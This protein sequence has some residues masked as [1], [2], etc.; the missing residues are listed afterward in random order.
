MHYIR[1]LV[2]L[3]AIGAPCAAQAQ[4]WDAMPDRYRQD[5][6]GARP[7]PGYDPLGIPLLGMTLHSD[8]AVATSYDSNIFGRSRDVVADG[9]I[10]IRPAMKM[11]GD[12][13]RYALTL[14]AQG[15]FTRFFDLHDQDSD[16]YQLGADGRVNL[17]SDLSLG[18]GADFGRQLESR[19]T[20]GNRLLSGTPVLFDRLAANLSARYRSGP[21]SLELTGAYRQ[22]RYIRVRSVSGEQVDQSF[23]D[24]NGIGGRLELAYAVGPALG[25][26]TQVV[27]DRIENPHPAFASVRRAHGVAVLGGLRFDSGGLFVGQAALGYRWR[28]FKAAGEK[29]LSGMTYDVRLEWYPRPLITV[30]FTADRKL[31]N[32]GFLSASE[33]LVDTQALRI[34]YEALRNLLVTIALTDETT[35]YRALATKADLKTVSARFTYTPRRALQFSTFVNA[36]FNHSNRQDIA[37]GYHGY[38]AGFS[39]RVRL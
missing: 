32:S 16:E 28:T 8:V 13:Q 37:S 6:A 1:T 34:D 10:S 38:H 35:A 24:S 9:T 3:L 22:L 2:P 23:R 11:S 12:W 30:A 29:P 31:S 33:A 39:A 14:Q 25:L 7:Q 36:R 26:V 27:A 21:L 20:S 19:G 17:N 4:V 5:V 18:A 15:N